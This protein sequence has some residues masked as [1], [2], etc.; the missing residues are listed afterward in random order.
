MAGIEGERLLIKRLTEFA[1]MPTRG[2]EFA[3]GSA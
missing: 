1:I 3:A 2:S